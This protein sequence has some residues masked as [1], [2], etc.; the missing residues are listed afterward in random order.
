MIITDMAKVKRKKAES[1]FR[2]NPECEELYTD[3]EKIIYSYRYT[4]VDHKF[5]LDNWLSP[6]VDLGIKLNINPSTVGNK[7]GKMTKE[8]ERVLP[9]RLVRRLNDINEKFTV[10]RINNEDITSELVDDLDDIRDIISIHSFHVS[11]ELPNS[12]QSLYLSLIASTSVNLEE[13]KQEHDTSDL[14]VEQV[15]ALRKQYQSK[16]NVD[17]EIQSYTLLELHSVIDKLASFSSRYISHVLRQEDMDKVLY[18]LN[19]LYSS[20]LKLDT[21]EDAPEVIRALSDMIDSK[22]SDIG[23]LNNDIDHTGG[24]IVETY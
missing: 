18:V 14:S 1:D 2:I 12:I 6:E 20:R 11:D 17:K 15:T 9:R 3:L 4:E 8:I 22:V 23:V 24:I 21:L 19:I 10:C 7:K 13:F 16:G 5:L